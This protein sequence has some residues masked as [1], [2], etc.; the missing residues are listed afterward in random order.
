MRKAPK[1]IWLQYFEDE[2][3]ADDDI[4]WCPDK[5]N[6]DDVEYIRVVEEAEARCPEC[7]TAHK[8]LPDGTLCYNCTR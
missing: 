2:E 8:P 3:D 7:D 6:D 4:T 1:R 5:I